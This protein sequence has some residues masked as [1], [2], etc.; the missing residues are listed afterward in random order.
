MENKYYVYVYL[1]QR[2]PGTWG[3]DDKNFEFQPFYVGKGIKNR[4][5]QH[6]MPFMLNK[7]SVK[8][9]VIK[10]IIRETGEMPIHFRLF[11]NLGENE[12]IEIEKKII[13]HFG[14][15]DIG[16]GILANGTDGGDGSSNMSE[17]SKKRINKNR[18]KNIYQYDLSGNF[19]KKWN[20]IT[21]VGEELGIKESNI[22][23]SIKRNGSCENFIWSYSYKG[24]KIKGKIKYQM[25]TKYTVVKQIDKNNN[26]VLNTFSTIKEAV[27]KLSFPKG[28]KGKIVSAA[29]GKEGM[30]T[31][32]GF[33]WE[34]I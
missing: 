9:S 33:K 5:A 18:R 21:E 25:P 29:L 10:S 24:K 13:A 4:I 16:T 26:K 30:K 22:S 28:A 3:F 1:D 17:S 32:K 15:R 23:T 27:D 34:I 20:S 2:K 14:R 12:A 7:K 6:L 31:Y 11:E 8:S 19:I